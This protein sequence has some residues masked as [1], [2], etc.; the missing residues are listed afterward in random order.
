MYP[1][2]YELE[3]VKGVP[4]GGTVAID[5]IDTLKEWKK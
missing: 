2:S 4:A 1:K 3:N 5:K